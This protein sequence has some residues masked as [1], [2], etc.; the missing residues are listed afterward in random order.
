MV[1]VFRVPCE[2]GHVIPHQQTSCRKFVTF[3]KNEK[4]LPLVHFWLLSCVSSVVCGTG[5]RGRLPQIIVCLSFLRIIQAFVLTFWFGRVKLNPV[6]QLTGLSPA[7]VVDM[8]LWFWP[9]HGLEIRVIP[10]DELFRQI[11]CRSLRTAAVF[12][13][14]SVVFSVYKRFYLTCFFPLWTIGKE[15]Q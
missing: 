12:G 3:R 2:N 4:L 9:R 14:F 6:L 1:F 15:C 11:F 13:C 7:I 10:T 8:V 5:R